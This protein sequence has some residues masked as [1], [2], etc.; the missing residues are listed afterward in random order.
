MSRAVPRSG[1]SIALAACVVAAL[2]LLPALSSGGGNHKRL[3][4]KDTGRG[5]SAV[6]VATAT[7]RNPHKLKGVLTSDPHHLKIEW[8]YT[9]VCSRDGRTE[10]Y[11]PAG[12]HVTM[13]DRSKVRTNIK[14]PLDNP[15]KCTVS[16]FGKLG[17]D[18]GKRVTA[19][20]YELR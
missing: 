16:L 10:R 20:I 13:K 6:A 8:S 7:V 5:K 3:L 18:K 9:N 11:P 4:D 1:I 12:D 15:D 14:K 19:K 2:L 17:Y